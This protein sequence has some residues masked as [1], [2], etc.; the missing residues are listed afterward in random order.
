MYCLNSWNCGGGKTPWNTWV[1]CEEAPNGN[2]YQVDPF[3]RIPA[4]KLTLGSDGGKL[5]NDFDEMY[6]AMLYH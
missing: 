5:D 3:D 2:I 1:S 4:E 6:V